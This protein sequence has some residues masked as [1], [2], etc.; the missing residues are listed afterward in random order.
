MADAVDKSYCI[1]MC[2]TEAYGKSYNCHSEAEYAYN[3][4]KPIIPLIMQIGCQ[5]SGGWLGFI[6]G[7]KQ[8]VNFADPKYEFEKQID[9]LIIEISNVLKHSL[10]N[11]NN[12]QIKES[13]TESLV[14]EWFVKEKIDT[15]I[16]NFLGKCNGQI[17]KQLWEL[18]QN[19][20]QFFL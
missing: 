20:P 17:L 4:Q 19:L 6:M 7:S 10:D 18:R 1:L 12:S 15:L 13:M 9:K 2:V 11:M 14:E 5:N 3:K 16:V 8:Y